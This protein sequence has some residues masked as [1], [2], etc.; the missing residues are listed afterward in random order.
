V[1]RKKLKIISA[2]GA[3]GSKKCK[4]GHGRTYG[5]V[6]WN[7]LADAKWKHSQLSQRSY[8]NTFFVYCSTQESFIP[9]N[10]DMSHH[11]NLNI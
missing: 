7:L 4:Q 2:R 3:S 10:S 8:C 5:G 11:T 9:F 6:W 1:I